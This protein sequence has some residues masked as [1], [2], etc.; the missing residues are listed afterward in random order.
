[1]TNKKNQV[2]KGKI[3]VHSRGFGFVSVENSENDIFIPKPYMNG[4]VHEDIVEIEIENKVTSKGP[5]GK[6][7]SIIERARST[8]YCILERESKAKTY[9]AF[10]PML[11]ASKQ[12]LVTLSKSFKPK[13]GDRIIAKVKDWG[14]KEKP[15]LATMQDYI[16]NIKDAATD[17]PSA[18][19]EFHLH[20]GFSK[21][22][23]K[24]AKKYKEPST[25]DL[26][27]GRKDLTHLLSFTVDPTT[28]KDFDDALFVD[29]NKDGTY[30]L[31]IHIA[32]VSHYV[33]P[34]TNL[35]EEAYTRGN[36]TYLPGTCLPMIPEE[37][38]N[39]LCSL[40]ENVP[41]FTISVLTQLSK[42]GDLIHYEI[43]KSIIKSQK[44]FTYEEAMQVLDGKISHPLLPKL[45]LLTEIAMLLKKKR[46][47]RGSV[48]LS[49]KEI[50][51]EYDKSGNPTGFHVIEYDIT[52]QMVE[53][54][55]L[56]A[57]EIVATKLKERKGGSLYRIHESP[58]KEQSG[59]FC[60]LA[61]LLGYELAQNPTPKDIQEL[62]EKAKNSP[63]SY[64]LSTAYIRSMKLA[65]YS[66]ENVGHFGLCLENYT[67][68]TSPIRR[69]S[70]LVI[71]RLLFE[72]N[73]KPDLKAIAEHCSL[74]ERASFKA[75]MSVLQLKKMRL[76]NSM[77]EKA[78]KAIY[79]AVIT[80]VNLKGVAFELEN[81][82][83]DGF[84]AIRNLGPDYYHYEQ[85]KGRLIGSSSKESFYIGKEIEVK[86]LSVDLTLLE[87]EWKIV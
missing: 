76:L 33:K 9:L 34:G 16:G 86:L 54:C 61:T 67:H 12:I 11:G 45:Q 60:S 40:K 32:D 41:R 29:K 59:D 77:L 53:E 74:T 56:L 65:I 35:D 73:Y 71:H 47:E 68:F 80:K 58:T 42:T 79:P 48:D 3:S 7:L 44:R 37:L 19:A 2:V 66:S 87:V 62:F 55:M 23:V 13:E 15:I 52:H 72:K 46:K 24:E 64:Q 18:V 10:S 57:N 26:E 20:H 75:E 21:Q 4:A 27:E 50:S 49:T 78:P 83:T 36:S 81:L 63:L 31:A 14:E 84:I 5:E 70:D 6:V 17:I 51:L 69:Y 1:M 28:A 82:L 43:T 22:T 25:K 38:S 39:E 8:I 85:Q 30:S